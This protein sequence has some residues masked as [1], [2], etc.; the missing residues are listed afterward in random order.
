MDPSPALCSSF[1]ECSLICLIYDTQMIL[2]SLFSAQTSLFGS[3]S[4]YLISYETSLQVLSPPWVQHIQVSTHATC[5]FSCIPSL[6]Y[7]TDFPVLPPPYAMLGHSCGFFPF[8]YFWNLSPLHL[9]TV[10]IFFQ[11]PIISFLDYRISFLMVFLV[12]VLSLSKCPL[13]SATII[14]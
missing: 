4:E 14:C 1:H 7:I 6:S 13:H 8:T 11:A 12:L 9:Y 5:F 10:I 3:S 2:K